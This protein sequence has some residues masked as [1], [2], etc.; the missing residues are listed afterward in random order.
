MADQLALLQP[1]RDV[2]SARLANQ[3]Q[4]TGRTGVSVA[5]GGN[6][7]MAN[8]EQQALANAR[9]MQDLQ[10]AARAQ[11]EGRDRTTFGR[12]LLTGAY[13]P[14][15]A[16]IKTAAGVETLGR[17]PFDISTELAK[18]TSASG[19]NAGRL[20]LTADMSAAD[21]ILSANKN[22]PTAS[23][24][25]GLG[26]SSLFNNALGKAFGNTG[27]GSALAKYLGGLVGSGFNDNTG[28]TGGG[29]GI[30]T[31]D[32]GTTIN[33]ADYFKP[34]FESDINTSGFGDFTAAVEPDFGTD[35]YYR[36]YGVPQ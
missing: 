31:L 18:L 5:Q 28:F 7:G 33:L 17:Q 26:G 4:Q 16:G 9:S 30:V 23:V 8:P 24:L 34:Q 10:L 29:S 15:N 19:A 32:D 22:S 1:G 14:F 2:E 36:K 11:Q 20:G 25:G 12:G 13:D 3:L 35:E 21:A 27:A 6:L